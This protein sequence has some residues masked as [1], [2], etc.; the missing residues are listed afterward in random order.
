MSGRVTGSGRNTGG[1]IAV[2]GGD[3]WWLMA[4]GRRGEAGRGAAFAMV[5]AEVAAT[6]NAKKKGVESGEHAVIQACASGEAIQKE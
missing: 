4:H 1:A 3:A 5:A 2:A 6:I